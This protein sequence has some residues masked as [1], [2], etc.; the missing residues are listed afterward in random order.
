MCRRLL[1]QVV[2]CSGLLPA[3]RLPEEQTVTWFQFHHYLQ[4][5]SVLDLERHFAQL[6]KEGG[7]Q[8]A[9]V[10]SQ[11]R[12][13]L[14]S[15]LGPHSCKPG[16]LGYIQSLCLFPSSCCFKDPDLIK[17][18]IQLTERNELQGGA[19]FQMLALVQKKAHL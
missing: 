6:T 12:V 1:E 10:A 11:H 8:L 14:R 16:S 7:A 4:R 2:T 17:F 13:W 19:G 15:I 5:Q 9:A 3:A 18:H